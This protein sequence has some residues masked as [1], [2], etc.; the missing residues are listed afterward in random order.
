MANADSAILRG[1]QTTGNRENIN[2]QSLITNYQSLA[3]TAD[4]RVVAK[5]FPHELGGYQAATLYVRSIPVLTFLSSSPVVA[6][7]IKLGDAIDPNEQRLNKQDTAANAQDDPVLRSSAIAAKLNQLSQDKVDASAITVTWKPA[8]NCY[9][10]KVKDEELV[11]INA[12]TILPDTTR[13][14][15]QDALQATNRLRRLMGNAPP[16]REIVGRSVAVVPK[17]QIATAPSVPSIRY[18]ISGLASWYGTGS[19][20]VESA[21]GERLNATDLTAAH[22]TLPFGTRVRVTN[23]NNG[24]S[25]VV[26][27]NDRGPFIGGRVIDLSVAAAQVIGMI[28]SGVAPVQVDVLGTQQTVS[29]SQE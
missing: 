23:L 3:S 27:I 12:K 4:G 22:R 9:A 13:N 6:R 28:Q 15:T 1:Q 7:S 2:R 24:R 5:I 8:C 25:V 20:E 14:P 16:L 26:R 17:P 18:Q 19:E 29:S 11:E 10:I 21:S